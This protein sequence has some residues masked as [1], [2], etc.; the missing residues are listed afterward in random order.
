MDEKFNK[1]AKVELLTKMI[2]RIEE[3]KALIVKDL[4]T[5]LDNIWAAVL[6]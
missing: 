4:L 6:T 5:K 1:N 2:L 3:E